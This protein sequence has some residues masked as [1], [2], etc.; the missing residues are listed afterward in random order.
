MKT[1]AIT[2]SHGL[3]VRNILRTEV[4]KFLKADKNVRVAPVILPLTSFYKS[5]EF[6][7]EFNDKNVEV[8]NWPHKLNGMEWLLRKLED[9]LFF[10]INHVDTIRIKEMVQKKKNY[11]K[12]LLF[13]TIG[14]ILGKNR[15]LLKAMEMFDR[16]VF[17]YKNKKYW[18][19]F[20]ENKP[21]LVF[22]TDFL[23]TYDWGL[24]KAAKYYKVPVI[25]MVASWDHLT[26]G[27]LPTKFDRVIVWNDFLKEQLIEYYGYKPE[28]IFVSGIP[29]FDYYVKLKKKILPREKFLK[30]VGATPKQKLITYT[31]SP[32]TLSPHEPEI[33]EVICEAIKSRKIKYPAHVHVRFHPGDNFSRYEKL[34][35]YEGLVTF[36]EPG[37]SVSTKNFVWNPDWEDMTH[38]AGLLSHSDVVINVC[39]T[40]TIDASAFDTPVINIAFDGHEKKPYWDSALR[41]YD[42]THYKRIVSTK[43]A[44][45]ARS[46]EELIKQI[47]GYLNNPALDREGRKRI[48]KE[49]SYKF[50]GKAGERIAKYILNFLNESGG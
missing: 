38:Y 4:L 36:E 30:T 27:M 40:V 12:Y 37:K 23:C 26:K 39:S 6:A 44:K 34:K 1:I 14:K 35:K 17:S 10:N 18:N 29:Q 3:L 25:A 24:V 46:E 5:K 7:T 48:V 41:Y 32:P 31:T 33:I 47:N 11:P 9:I 19:V 20:G 45:I 21:S 42:Y 43:G 49:M 13:A 28:E 8:V 22:S 15:N 50:D 16:S 2:I